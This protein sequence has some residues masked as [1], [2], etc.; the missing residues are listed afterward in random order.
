MNSRRTLS[1]S[2]PMPFHFLPILTLIRMA[3][4][5]YNIRNFDQ[6]DKKLPEVKIFI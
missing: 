1:K 5:V 2:K 4:D 6:V 3:K